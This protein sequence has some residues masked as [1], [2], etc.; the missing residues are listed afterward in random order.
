M[1]IDAYEDYLKS[2][3]EQERILAPIYNRVVGSCGGDGCG[4][5][6]ND[7]LLRLD[8][9]LAKIDPEYVVFQFKEKFGTL[10]YYADLS[11]DGDHGRPEEMQDAFSER[12]DKAEEESAKTCEYC[13]KPGELDTRTHWVKTRCPECMAATSKEKEINK[14]L[15][16]LKT[17]PVVDS[18]IDPNN[19]VPRKELKEKYGSNKNEI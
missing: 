9:D 7:L 15:E 17:F 14:T 6:W 5:G 16:I 11:G 18:I 19:F 8:A 4:S 2:R 1:L 3:T 12:I 10:R 13:G